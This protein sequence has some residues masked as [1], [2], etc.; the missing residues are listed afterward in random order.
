[1]SRP[2]DHFQ[3]Y[4]STEGILLEPLPAYYKQMDGHT[5]I[6]NKEV[7]MIVYACELEG[8]QLVQQLPEILLELNRR[9]D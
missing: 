7:V 2:H 8:D 3:T 5:E 4:T 9:Y 1:M 6:I